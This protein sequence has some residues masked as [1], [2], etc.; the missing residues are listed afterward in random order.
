MNSNLWESIHK[1]KIEIKVDFESEYPSNELRCF[2]NYHVRPLTEKNEYKKLT[3]LEIGGGSGVGVEYAINLIESI[4][5]LIIADISDSALLACKQKILNSKKSFSNIKQIKLI[6]N[7]LPISTSSV[8]IVHAEASLYYNDF[9]SLSNSIEEILRVLRPGGLARIT[10]KADDDRYAR[11]DWEIQKYT[12]KIDLPA[13]WENGMTVTCLPEKEVK[14][15]FKGFNQIYVGK[16][17]YS[18]INLKDF[19]SFWIITAIK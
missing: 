5:N 19:K 11:K 6:K 17:L 10:L 1:N 12:Y 4:D 18:L 3:W 9:L 8:D 16:E 7:S 15:I 2:L 13:H 14:K